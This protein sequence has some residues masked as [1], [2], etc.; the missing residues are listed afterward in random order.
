MTQPRAG[1]ASACSPSPVGR[2]RR[3]TIGRIVSVALVLTLGASAS[4]KRDYDDL[5]RA[6]TCNA[7]AKE[8][9]LKDRQR[10][11]FTA[12]CLRALAKMIPLRDYVRRDDATCV[13]LM[14]ECGHCPGEVMNK[15]CFVDK[16]SPWARQTNE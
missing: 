11:S 10:E 16:S 3:D 6:E 8:K 5:V 7:L 15:S 1:T 2:A 13:A 12:A 14:P 9:A 4:C